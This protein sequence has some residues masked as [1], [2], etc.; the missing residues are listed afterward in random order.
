MLLQPIII[1]GENWVPLQWRMCLY[2]YRLSGRE[3]LPFWHELNIFCFKLKCFLDLWFLPLLN[4]SITCR[5]FK[6]CHG[7][8][9]IWEYIIQI[10]K[11][12]RELFTVY[13]SKD[14]IMRF[15][16]KDMGHE[17]QGLR[18]S[19]KSPVKQ[20][21]QLESMCLLDE[22]PSA[23]PDGGMEIYQIPTYDV[24]SC[25]LKC[26]DQWYVPKSICPCES[27]QWVQSL[28]AK[29]CVLVTSPSP[30]TA[31]GPVVWLQGEADSTWPRLDLQVG[32]CIS[33]TA[34]MDNPCF[35][36]GFAALYTALH[37]LDCGGHTRTHAYHTDTHIQTCHAYYI[38]HTKVHTIYK[39]I[40][41]FGLCN[42][43]AHSGI[44]EFYRF[45]V[46][47]H[48]NWYSHTDPLCSA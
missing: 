32:S 12:H 7:L 25:K 5:A 19:A 20:S 26:L 37:T 22:S 45:A 29:S 39:S 35:S 8:G 15:L 10:W 31:L 33:K 30:R 16:I 43:P 23:S 1:E 6:T 9:A 24:L 48:F 13:G 11:A 40:S 41:Q 18:W 38:L 36:S 46:T 28:S 14:C 2:E 27:R 47:V 4:I 21:L 3:S 17:L 44:R 34:N 42:C